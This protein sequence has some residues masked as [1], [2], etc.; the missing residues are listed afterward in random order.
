MDENPVILPRTCTQSEWRVRCLEQVELT[1]STGR[2]VAQSTGTAAS[3]SKRDTAEVDGDA[4]VEPVARKMPI[5][6]KG[7]AV[8]LIAG[9]DEPDNAAVG[10]ASGSAALSRASSGK[11]VGGKRSRSPSGSLRGASKAILKP[12]TPLRPATPR[13]EARVM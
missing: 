10:A 2:F 8:D 13:S 11:A 3:G 9:G 7:V 12:A 4:R 1:M 5:S 6:K